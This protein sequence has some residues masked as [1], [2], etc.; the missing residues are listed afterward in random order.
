MPIRVLAA[1]DLALVRE[2][3]RSALRNVGDMEIVGEATCAE[4]VLRLA[5][6]TDPQVVLLD[7]EMPGGDGLSVVRELREALPVVDVL[8]MTDRLD[9]TQA[10]EA[11]EAGATGYILKDIPGDNLINAIRAVCNGRA[12]FHPDLSRRVLDHL[13]RLARQERARQ[14]PRLHRLTDREREILLELAEGAKDADIA[15]KFMVSEGTVKTHV[16][17]IL[18]KMRVRTRTQAVAYVLRQGLIK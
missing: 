18:Q 12:Y 15:R 17:N 6:E 8:V 9:D 5:R 1:D 3:I 4:D 7:L 11:I 16:H 10:L 2:G 14:Q 13:G